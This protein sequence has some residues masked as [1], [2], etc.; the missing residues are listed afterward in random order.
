MQTSVQ[1]SIGDQRS[2]DTCKHHWV[3]DAANGP[4]SRGRCK[5]C[6]DER[7][8]FNNPEDALIP[9]EEHAASS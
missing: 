7:D 9:R 6:G 1:T 8:F 5:R 3:I 2:I 4:T